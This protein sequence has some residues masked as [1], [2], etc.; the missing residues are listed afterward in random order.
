MKTSVLVPDPLA[1]VAVSAVS[2]T[3][4]EI[5]GVPPVVS[6]HTGREYRTQ[7]FVGSSTVHRIVA[8]VR[9]P[10]DRLAAGIRFAGGA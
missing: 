7:S 9:P 3:L 5:L 1:Q 6:I 2:P 4:S 8:I 10:P